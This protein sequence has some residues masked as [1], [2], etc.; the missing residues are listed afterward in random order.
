MFAVSNLVHL[1][2]GAAL[3]KPKTLNPSWGA[4]LTGF[5]QDTVHK[6]D[7]LAPAVADQLLANMHQHPA[8]AAVAVWLL[9]CLELTDIGILVLLP[10]NEAAGGLA[11]TKSNA[12]LSALDKLL[13]MRHVSAVSN[14]GANCK[15]CVSAKPLTH[16][17]PHA[18][19]AQ[20][21]C[22]EF[23]FLPLTAHG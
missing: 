9:G 2:L 6:V 1:H 18:P 8:A 5:G 17:Q 13:L 10:S 11:P 4:W 16:I 23:L 22:P 20:C 15:P 19:G 21:E 14:L 7:V 12:D 3:A